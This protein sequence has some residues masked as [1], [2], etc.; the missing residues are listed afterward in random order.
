MNKKKHSQQRKKKKINRKIIQ[1]L[2]ESEMRYAVEKDENKT[3]DKWATMEK[4]MRTERH[5]SQRR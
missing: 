1:K 5:T 2:R 4:K 3:W